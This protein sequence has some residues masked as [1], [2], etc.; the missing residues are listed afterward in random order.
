MNRLQRFLL[1][2]CFWLFVWFL[3]WMEKDWTL[4]Y[5]TE[6]ATAFVAQALLIASL[7]Y[8]ATPQL[9]LKKKH[10][11]F[12]LFSILAIGIF[13]FLSSSFPS[14]VNMPPPR[15]NMGPPGEMRGAFRRIGPSRF[16]VNILLITVS[17]ILATFIETFIF[18]QKK[19]EETIHN[20]NEMLQTELKL[21]K[22]QINPHFLFNALNNI[23]ALSV[24]DSNRTQ[25]SISY[26]SNMLRYVLYE[27]EEKL[28]PLKK[29]IDYI[30]D[31]I[32]LYSLKSSKPYNIKTQYSIADSNVRVAP[33]LFIPFVE[34]A[35]KHS[36]IEKHGDSFISI[37]V[38]VTSRTIELEIENSQPKNVINKDDVGGIGIGNVKK[39]LSILYPEKHQLS[40]LESSETFKIKLNLELSEK[41]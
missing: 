15:G 34:N 22:S 27:C 31:F 21:L 13:S 8:Y 41:N 17:Y 30:N 36:H 1:Q 2:F 24:I 25:E 35:F 10:A 6:N 4:R 28:V 33:M 20:K 3:L 37:L 29:E 18:A 16:F 5:F 32:K 14:G 12:L 39:R 26:L 9:L 38:S 11:Q 7:I 23:Y 40:I 19:Q